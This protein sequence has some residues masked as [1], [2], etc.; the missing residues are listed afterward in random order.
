MLFG[1]TVTTRTYYG[2]SNHWNLSCLANSLLR[3]TSKKQKQNK[4]ESLP[5]SEGNP[6]VMGGLPSPKVN[7]A[8]RVTM[9]W[10]HHGINFDINGC[11]GCWWQHLYFVETLPRR[12]ALRTH[13]RERILRPECIIKSYI[14]LQLLIYCPGTLPIKALHG[15]FGIV[16]QQYRVR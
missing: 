10:C 3:L 2:V 12:A 15:E 13:C 5:L 16:I 6:L 1:F 7:N 9:S 4:I 14:E 11:S 8:E